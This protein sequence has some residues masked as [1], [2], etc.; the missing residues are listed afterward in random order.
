[1]WWFQFHGW[2]IEWKHGDS[3]GCI[4]N[5]S[6][7][8]G[9]TGRMWG[10][11]LI[12]YKMATLASIYCMSGI[13][14]LGIWQSSGHMFGSWTMEGSLPGLIPN[15][16]LVRRFIDSTPYLTY[17]NQGWKKPSP[18]VFLGFFGVFLPRRESF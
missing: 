14:L 15:R 17:G 7:V 4:N 13:P 5:D 8:P 12:G 18:V 11:S 1:M 3:F 6:Q 16:T 10:G 9:L 2:L